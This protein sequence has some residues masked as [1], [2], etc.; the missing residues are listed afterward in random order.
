[1]T[2]EQIEQKALELFPVKH[3]ENKKGTGE[4]DSNLPRR[5]AYIQGAIE[6]LQGVWKDGQGDEL[7]EM[8]K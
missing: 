7:P 1:M 6:A 2:K 8:D 3:K 4:Y 5:K